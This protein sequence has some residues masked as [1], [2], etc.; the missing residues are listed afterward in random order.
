MLA[1]SLNQDDVI[2]FKQVK[3]KKAKKR[4]LLTII[5]T[6]GSCIFNLYQYIFMN[7]LQFI[8]MLKCLWMEDYWHAINILFLFKQRNRKITYRTNTQKKTN[9]KINW[10]NYMLNYT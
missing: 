6:L 2:K 7:I 3:K 5:N 4:T 9:T 1:S 10:K 8:K